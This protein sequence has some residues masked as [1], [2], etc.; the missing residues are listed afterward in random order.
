MAKPRCTKRGRQK[1]IR[2]GSRDRSRWRSGQDW[3]LRA[4]LGTVLGL[5]RA[6]PAGPQVLPKA[7]ADILSLERAVDERGDVSRTVTGVVALAGQ[8]HRPHRL[9]RRQPPHGVDEPDLAAAPGR[10]GAEDA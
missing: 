8:L 1:G 7:R 3:A 6:P 9:A 10:E 2:G 5:R 4:R